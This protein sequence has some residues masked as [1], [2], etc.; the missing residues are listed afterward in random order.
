MLQSYDQQLDMLKLYKVYDCLAICTRWAFR[1]RRRSAAAQML[2][3]L[4]AS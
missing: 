3:C 4:K 2:L 1:L